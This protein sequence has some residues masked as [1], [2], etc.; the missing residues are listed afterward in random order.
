LLL[1]LLNCNHCKHVFSLLRRVLV[2]FRCAFITEHSF[3]SRIARAHFIPLPLRCL[4]L[5]VA[6]ASLIRFAFYFIASGT[7]ETLTTDAHRFV[8]GRRGDAST[9]AR[10]QHSLAHRAGGLIARFATPAEITLASCCL[11][12]APPM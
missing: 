1:L 2:I 4:A 8:C 11:R 3:P 10:T 9:M 5:A 6:I 12:I 7:N